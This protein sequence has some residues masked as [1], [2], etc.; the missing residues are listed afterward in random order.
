MP[1][2][3]DPRKIQSQLRT[4]RIGRVMHAFGELESTNRW[5]LDRPES[6]DVDGMV[7]LA[8]RQTAGKGRQGRGWECP[9]GA[10]L[11]LTIGLEGPPAPAMQ[12]LLALMVPV[13]ICEALDAATEIHAEI[14][15]PND[16]VVDGR[17]LGGI[18]IETRAGAGKTRTAIGIGLNCLQQ[19]AHFPPDLRPRATSLEILSRGA[20]NRAAVLTAVLEHLDRAIANPPAPNQLCAK[21]RTRA[22]GLGGRVKLCQDGRS[23]VGNILDIDP[24]AAILVQLDEGG[25]RLFEAAHTHILEI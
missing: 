3:I 4:T 18:L 16:I 9:N 24:T 11:L 22:V 17:K 20:V 5:L 13:A 12:S 7:V 2:P 10:G 14:K 21:W 15:W 23:Y 25:R 6:D 19:A 8:E 1:S